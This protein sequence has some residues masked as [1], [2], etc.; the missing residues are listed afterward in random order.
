MAATLFLGSEKMIKYFLYGGL[1]A[2]STATLFLVTLI[3]RLSLTP[4]AKAHSFNVSF[5]I[6]LHLLSASWGTGHLLSQAGLSSLDTVLPKGTYP[7]VIAKQ[8][9]TIVNDQQGAVRVLNDPSFEAAKPLLEALKFQCHTAFTKS[10][11]LKHFS[12]T[13]VR[14]ACFEA[15]RSTLQ[16][17]Q[18][19]SDW[20]NFANRVCHDI[21]GCN[22]FVR[23]E[24][25]LQKLLMN[26]QPEPFNIDLLRTAPVGF[27]KRLLTDQACLGD[28]SCD[29]D[30]VAIWSWL[31]FHTIKDA[32]P[33]LCRV[34]HHYPQVLQ[35]VHKCM[36]G[37]GHRRY[38]SG[39]VLEACRMQTPVGYV[40][41]TASVTSKLFVPG[42][43][44][45]IPLRAIN[46][47]LYKRPDEFEPTR[48]LNNAQH[49][50]F[51]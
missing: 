16:F 5:R 34:L 7:V 22:S 39:C 18:T 11:T 42:T 4:E 47:R 26:V 40:M 36:Q 9:W 24:A 33:F 2:A 27:V 48:W 12:Y 43:N 19:E 29:L 49:D 30:D 13:D 17:P 51:L 10:H 45:L 25:L 23:V 38:I 6:N 15:V 28:T 21:V 35:E 14:S 32:V 31:L 3:T 50:T 8:V 44:V 20:E 46:N 37:A 1:A 41:R